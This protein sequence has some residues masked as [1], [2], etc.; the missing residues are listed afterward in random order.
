MSNNVF[1]CKCISSKT[2]KGSKMHRPHDVEGSWTIF[3]VTLKVKV[4]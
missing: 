4:N 1:S 2:I 3:C